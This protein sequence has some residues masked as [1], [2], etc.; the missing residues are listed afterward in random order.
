MGYNIAGV[1]TDTKL[2][3]Q[4][5]LKEVFQTTLKYI[6]DVDSESAT[7]PKHSS[8][9]DVYTNNKGSLVLFQL[10]ELYEFSDTKGVFIQF[11]ISDVS[12]TY[13]FEK[14][15][16]GQLERKLIVSQGEFT[17]DEGIGIIDGDDDFMDKV[18]ELSNELLAINDFYNLTFKRYV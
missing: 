16:N 1:L 14:Y 4:E 18:L 11:M 10:G 2:N 13:Y 9:Y 8:E 3:N 15:N 17:E 6:E 12:D 5:D 7:I